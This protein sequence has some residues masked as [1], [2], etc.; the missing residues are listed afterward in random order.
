MLSSRP[1]D[2]LSMNSVLAKT[3]LFPCGRGQ[4]DALRALDEANCAP[5]E[6]HWVKN[7][8]ALIVWKLA[9]LVRSKPD[10]LPVWR[11]ETVLDQLKYR[12]V[13]RPCS[14]VC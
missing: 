14:N 1:V 9:S 10:E 5:L 8:W 3:Y 4:A 7:H 11:W 12:Y 13:P 6:S 2:L